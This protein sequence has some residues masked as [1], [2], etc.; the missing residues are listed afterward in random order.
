V[1]VLVGLVVV[2][3]V[4][5]G[6]DG[7]GRLF[8]VSRTTELRADPLPPIPPIRYPD[9]PTVA[10]AA[11][12]TGDGSLPAARTARVPGSKATMRSVGEPPAVPPRT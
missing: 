1:L 5:G 4:V 8:A 7:A 11:F 12:D 9:P 3:E 6:W 2:L 10:A